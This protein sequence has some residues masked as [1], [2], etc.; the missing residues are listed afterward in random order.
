MN[1]ETRHNYP[2][3]PSPF[4][5]P[6]HPVEGKP[7]FCIRSIASDSG[8][9]PT[10]GGGHEDMTVNYLGRKKPNKFM[11]LSLSIVITTKENKDLDRDHQ[12]S[13]NN[14]G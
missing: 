7:F 1:L 12:E 3:S 4:H 2:L 8:Q 9:M 10:K 11:A 5:P 6:P 13:P 14:L